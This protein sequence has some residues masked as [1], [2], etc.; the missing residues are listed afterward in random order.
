MRTK[1]REKK[2]GNKRTSSWAS[3]YWLTAILFCVVSV[4]RASAGQASS[5]SGSPTTRTIEGTVLDHVGHP[6]SG[7][8]VLI[9][10]L[11]TL[12]VRS[13]IVQQDGR[14][15]F[16]GLSPDANYQLR[17]RLNG[18]SSGAKTVSV[19]QSK[20]VIVVNLKLSL[21]QKPPAQPA[22]SGNPS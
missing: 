22:S 2:T 17:A 9:E 11:K 15:R 12:Q 16:R 6:V 21:K 4:L 10:D 13:F 7:A 14:Y 20:S 5:V 1:T 18:L 8:I 19:F 3:S